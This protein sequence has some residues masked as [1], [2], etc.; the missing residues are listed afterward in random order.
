MA[1]PPAQRRKVGVEGVATPGQL[2]GAAFRAIAVIAENLT[3]ADDE[4]A[5]DEGSGET[6]S[7]DAEDQIL[8]SQC[9]DWEASQEGHALLLAVTPTAAP[10]CGEPDS[11]DGLGE[12]QPLPSDTAAGLEKTQPLPNT[13][14]T[15][16]A[17]ITGITPTVTEMPLFHGRYPVTSEQMSIIEAM[18]PPLNAQERRIIRVTAAAGAGKTYVVQRCREALLRLGHC[19]PMY[20]AFNKKAQLDMLARVMR[21]TPTRGRYPGYER[22]LSQNIRTFHSMAMQLVRLK[23][24]GA[25]LQGQPELSESVVKR[26][27]ARD[28]DAL[29]SEIS[30]EKVKNRCRRKV[31]RFIAKMFDSF[32]HSDRPPEDWAQLSLREGLN[33]GDIVCF[34]IMKWHGLLSSSQAQVRELPTSQE[35]VTRF[36]RGAVLQL[37]DRHCR[38]APSGLLVAPFDVLYASVY[39]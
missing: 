33:E 27:C 26:V 31:Y 16:A 20:I 38:S 36:Y 19:Q 10:L 3:A 30:E 25:R 9:S 15:A 8:L 6:T 32:C 18:G 24:G 28:V 2:R 37:W 21:D 13:A 17:E 22:K 5:A 1:T 23:F 11:E 12:T 14:A 4:W 29:L 39:F 34:H 7:S 35:T